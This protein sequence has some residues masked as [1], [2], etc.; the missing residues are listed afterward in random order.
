MIENRRAIVFLISA[1]A[2]AAAANFLVWNDSGG[3]GRTYRRQSLVDPAFIPSM[4]TLQ[5]KG[6]EPMVLARTARWRLVEPYQGSVDEQVVMKLLDA[7]SQREI[8]DSIS[9]KELL[10]LG[11]TRRDF[12]LVN[13]RVSVELSDLKTKL[14][15]SFGSITPSGDGVYAAVDSVNA[16]FTVPSEI[17]SAI[18]LPVD[19]FRRK[20]LFLI[21]G[22]SVSAFDVK[23]DGELLNFTRSAEGWQ[24]G[25]VRASQNKVKAL[26][27]SVV[28]AGAEGFVWPVGASNEAERVSA[29][30]LSVYELDSESAVTV[31]LKGYDSIDR[32][33]M[34]GKRAG[35][36]LVYALV[37]NGGAIVTVPEKLKT[38]SMLDLSEFTDTRLFPVEEESVLS[39]SMDDGSSV[40]AFRRERGGEWKIESPVSAPADSSQVEG[41]LKRTLALKAADAVPEGMK[42]SLDAYATPVTV[43][44]KSIL[45]DADFES[46]RSRE[47]LSLKEG[48]IR[49]I[50][51]QPGEENKSS[52]VVFDRDLKAW[53]PESGLQG[54]VV[55]AAAM[56][57]IL[58]ALCPLMSSRV[59]KLRVT[60]GDLAAAGLDEPVFTLAVDFADGRYPRRNI[61]FGKA[62]SG[63]RYVTVGVSD[64]IF[65][66]DDEVLEIFTAP[67]I[68]QKHNNRKAENP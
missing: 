45:G 66:V 2:A 61:L 18:D 39:F 12:A 50:V 33:V 43:A 25:G 65:I 59:E 38:L 31:T 56:A 48:E 64:A 16:V 30:L 32:Q 47:I 28:S 29:S 53:T 55:D 62:V 8:D 10:K 5:R 17:L 57:R 52:S 51:Q 22:E 20:S 40:Y 46:L 26:L 54:G 67:L 37:Q 60:A 24:V 63:G 3:I 27:D 15:V 49:R 19:R 9:D 13:P 4:I 44:K 1:I 21:A 68:K 41:V 14:R 7:L 23:R 6:E 34:F 11:R 58:K 36:N 42:V 35:E